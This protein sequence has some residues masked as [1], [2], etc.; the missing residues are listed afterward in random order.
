MSIFLTILAGVITFVAGQIIL[1]IYIEPVQ[2]FRTLIGEIAVALINYG[3][4]YRDEG[5]RS[6]EKIRDASVEFRL[7][8]S[9]LESSTY[10]IP[11]YRKVAQLF[12]LPSKHEIF[13]ATTNLI[14]ISDSINESYRPL[15]VIMDISNQRK[16]E[17]IRVLLKIYAPDPD[18]ILK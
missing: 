3:I 2:A 9:K 1:R 5:N 4:L 10:L 13:A 16:A 15:K 12:K 7:L 14:Q 17:E 18:Y 8:A 6:P 11:H